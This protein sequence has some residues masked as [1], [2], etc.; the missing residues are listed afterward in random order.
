MLPHPVH[1]AF[2]DLKAAFMA[3]DP[4]AGLSKK[5]LVEQFAENWWSSLRAHRV[6]SEYLDPDSQRRARRH[7]TQQSTAGEP[8]RHA[9]EQAQAHREEEL[10]TFGKS[11]R[12]KPLSSV[13]TEIVSFRGRSKRERRPPLPSFKKPPSHDDALPAGNAAT[14]RD[15]YLFK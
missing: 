9:D 8:G 1:A 15:S 6:E 12:K 5:F 13:R 4:P 7:R 2:E 3:R 11:P 14:V 10:P